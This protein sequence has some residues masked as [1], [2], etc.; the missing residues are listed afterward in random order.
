MSNVRELHRLRFTPSTVAVCIGKRGT[1]K[2]TCAK[3]LL[4]AAL[5]DGLRVLAWDPHDEYSRHGRESGQVRLGP[6][7]DRATFAELL[8][9][10]ELLDAPNLSLAVV[11]RAR[12]EEMAEDFAIF[13]PMVAATGGLLVCVEEVG[14]FEEFARS[15][16]NLLATQSRHWEVP[17]L[18]VAQ[19]ATQIPKTARTQITNLVSFRQDNP[20]DLRAL[21]DLAGEDFAAAVS[22]LGRGEHRTWRDSIPAA[23]AAAT[24]KEA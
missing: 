6:L 1:G 12:P 21:S 2:S 13:V 14:L 11:P 5:D 19:R 23:R 10:P 7:D 16:L 18:M 9:R 15:D 3:R 4:A 20:D 24:R 22:R 8:L 17:L